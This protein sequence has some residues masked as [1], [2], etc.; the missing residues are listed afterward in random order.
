ML[1]L[2]IMSF[3]P[4]GLGLTKT[5]YIND[6]LTHHKVDILFLQ[7][8][9]LS[10]GTMNRLN[11][12]NADYNCS[13]VSGMDETQLLSGRPYGGL[14]ILWRK[15]ISQHIKQVKHPSK[16]IMAMTLCYNDSKC[17]LINVYMPVDN[18]KKIH[19][20]DDF[21]AVCDDIECL[22]EKYTG[23]NIIIGGDLNVD[24]SRGNAHDNYF[25]S[26]LDRHH[27]ALGWRLNCAHK[28][29]TFE[30]DNCTSSS[31]IDHFCISDKLT[32]QLTEIVVV[33]S[34]LNPSGHNPI[35]MKIDISIQEQ[36]T[37]CQPRENSQTIAWHK[38]SDKHKQCYNSKLE[39][40]LSQV[41]CYDVT[42]CEDLLC[43][44]ND[45][46]MQINE[47]LENIVDCCLTAGEVFPKVTHVK[48]NKCLP[49]WSE[50]VKPY[51]QECVWWY[52]TWKY[53]GKPSVGVIFENMRESKRQYH[54]AVRR[55]KRQ[56]QTIRYSKMAE[57]ISTNK[58]RDFY[59]EIK[60]L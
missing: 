23:Y 57:C 48:S 19:V 41:N 30:N 24:F 36:Q 15:S 25:D 45:H 14:A 2:C 21:I 20:S 49:G 55:C 4:T 12:I 52:N 17:L 43:N 47:L 54:Y 18:Y 8:T 5:D 58:N 46:L 28:E 51:R 56:E 39:T 34:A 42:M 60:K 9:W 31:V 38:V 40:L 27:M 44:N 35:T 7:E 22:I 6:L 1:D 37:T 11:N 3:N 33:H 59:K 32:S 10:K 16:R 13:G 50:M 26:V 29:P 53:H